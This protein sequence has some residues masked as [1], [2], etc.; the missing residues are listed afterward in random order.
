M[1]KILAR[2]QE[3]GFSL[4]EARVYLALLREGTQNGNEVA[5]HASVPS[6]KVYAALDKLASEGLVQSS[7]HG[8]SRLWAAL[9]PGD[10][11]SKLR[12]QFNDPLDYLSD[13][14]PKIE[15]D[16]PS[17]PFLTISGV[18]PIRETALALIAS[19]EQELH[20]SCWEA[21]L[22]SLRSGLTDAADRGVQVFGM[23][24]GEA[25]HPPGSWLR[26]HY[27]EIIASRLEGRLLVLV[28]DDTA[29][30][31]ARIPEKGQASAVRSSNPV[32]TFIVKE[33]LHHDTVLQ[34]AQVRIGFEEWDRWWTADPQ[35]RAEIL[36]QAFD[37]PN[38]APSDVS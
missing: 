32:M 28:V 34:R 11:I 31:I 24:Y 6:S 8:T 26:H 23:L 38:T 1:Q 7:Q 9:P 36:G 12:R 18:D 17:E 22:G 2:L 5:K 13:E 35:A 16:K 29:A 14:L 4:Y 3:V 37:R 20:I 27:E 10:L 30:L 33:Y 21:D 15:T 19:A 25:K